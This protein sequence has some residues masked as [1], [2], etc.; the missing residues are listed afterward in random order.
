ML[1]GF[2]GNEMTFEAWLQTSDFCH[3]GASTPHVFTHR[4]GLNDA[5]T[6]LVG[7]SESCMPHAHAHRQISDKEASLAPSNRNMGS[8]YSCWGMLAGAIMSYALNSTATDPLERS[9]DFNHFLI[10]HP[11]A[12]SVCHDFAV[13]SA[14]GSQLCNQEGMWCWLTHGVKL[15]QHHWQPQRQCIFLLVTSSAA[16]QHVGAKRDCMGRFGL[17]A[18]CLSCPG[19]VH[20]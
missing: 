14:P 5:V 13:R 7:T 1:Q 18:C 8:I 16:K 10:L 6:F 19:P 17:H 11:M 20:K 15:Q 4:A 12:I 9:A 2:G 3:H